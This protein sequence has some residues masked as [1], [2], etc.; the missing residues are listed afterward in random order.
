MKFK[1]H[2][3]AVLLTG[4]LNTLDKIRKMETS[5]IYS[6]A[7]DLDFAR[8]KEKAKEKKKKKMLG[9]VVDRLA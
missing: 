3:G 8:E 7:N 2:E 5:R 9:A 1:S 4:F 6:S